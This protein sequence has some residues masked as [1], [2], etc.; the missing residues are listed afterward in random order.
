MTQEL[1]V[2]IVGVREATPDVGETT[3]TAGPEA[4]AGVNNTLLIAVSVF[5]C[6]V[7]FAIII[8]SVVLR[9]R[10]HRTNPADIT[11]KSLQTIRMDN[12]TAS[13]SSQP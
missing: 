5:L 7:L 9:R 1:N 3:V 10:N 8:G 2:T 4:G 11:R 13:N 12:I 6:I